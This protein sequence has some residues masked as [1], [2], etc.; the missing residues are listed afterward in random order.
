VVSEG[1]SEGAQVIVDGIQRVRPG[2]PVQAVPAQA[3]PRG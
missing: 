2:A 3:A 1:L